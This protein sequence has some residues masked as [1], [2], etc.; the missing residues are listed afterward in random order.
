MPTI[1]SGLSIAVDL[2]L[3]AAT[4]AAATWTATTPRKQI[5]AT[6]RLDPFEMI[7]WGGNPPWGQTP[8]Q[9]AE[10]KRP[11]RVK[12][13]RMYPRSPLAWLNGHPGV[14]A[15]EKALARFQ[16]KSLSFLAVASVGVGVVVLRRAGP[17][18]GRRR[19]GAGKVAAAVAAVVAGAELINEYVLRHWNLTKYGDIHC[20]L[21]NLWLYI[22]NDVGT[23]V[24]LAWL[25]LAGAG[26]WR[27]GRGWR[28]KLGVGLGVAWLLAFGWQVVESLAQ[29]YEQG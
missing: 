16:A 13:A 9:A 26:R 19:W 2:L 28:E 24:L 21:D 23:A 5:E 7:Q 22:L 20:P 25:V 8:E 12:Y 27:L 3:L 14:V 29:V 10:A 17:G 4:L 6:F 18:P 11:L 15:V 1:R